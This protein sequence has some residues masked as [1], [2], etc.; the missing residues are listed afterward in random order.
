M[1]D[2]TVEDFLEI[3]CRPGLDVLVARWLRPIELAE[4]QRG[5]VAL[6][7]SAAAGNHR[8]WLLDVRRLNTHLMGASWMIAQLLPQLGPCRGGHTRLAYLLAPAYARDESADATF[9]T[10]EYFIDKPFV[11]ERFVEERAAVDWLLAPEAATQ[12]GRSTRCWGLA[13]C[14]LSVIPKKYMSPKRPAALAFIFATILIDVIGLG[15]IIPVLPTLIEQ[16]TGEGVSWASQYAGGLSFAYA[17]AQFFFAP[18]IGGL[19]DG[20]GRR[21]VLLASLLGLT[22]SWP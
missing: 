5:Y 21:P 2:S 8:R 22:F 20:Y 7:A 11:G 19:S 6:L 16:L 12:P 18:V 3:T 4:L 14:L 10:P 17:A 15:V 1:P 9:P 13:C